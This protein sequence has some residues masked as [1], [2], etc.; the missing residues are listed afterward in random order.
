VAAEPY[1][2]RHDRS[3]EVLSLRAGGQSRVSSDAT[4]SAEH[5]CDFWDSLGGPGARR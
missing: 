2:P 3:H 4:L 5:R 1:W